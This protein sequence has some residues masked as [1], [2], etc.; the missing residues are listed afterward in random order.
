M[1]V[2]IFY[3]VHINNSSRQ[4]AIYLDGLPNWDGFCHITGDCFPLSFLGNK[5][6]SGDHMTIFSKML[7]SQKASFS[8]SHNT[9]YIVVARSTSNN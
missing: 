5:H 2:D 9:Q 4:D 6:K 1:L 3:W 8:L 7:G